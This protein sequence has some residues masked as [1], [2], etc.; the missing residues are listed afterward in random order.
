MLPWWLSECWRRIA[1]CLLCQPDG[2]KY[3]LSILK[4]VVG[5]IHGTVS[6]SLFCPAVN[7]R[8]P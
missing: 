4:L 6:E 5:S 1:A 7:E 2:V 3:M 8:L